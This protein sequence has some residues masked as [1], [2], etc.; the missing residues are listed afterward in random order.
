M[1]VPIRISCNF[2]LVPDKV[3]MG[4]VVRRLFTSHKEMVISSGNLLQML[5]RA[6]MFRYPKLHLRGNQTSGKPHLGRLA[7]TVE[8]PFDA[9]PAFS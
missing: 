1:R 4:V 6:G 7:R 8:P 5:H 3:V 9:A 2:I